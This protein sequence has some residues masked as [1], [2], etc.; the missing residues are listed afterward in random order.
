MTH[1]DVLRQ[2]ATYI[3]QIVSPVYELLNSKEEMQQIVQSFVLGFGIATLDM[4][5]AP[6]LLTI[7]ATCFAQSNKPE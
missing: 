6:S 4:T 5:K 3:T 7:L 1:L 2:L